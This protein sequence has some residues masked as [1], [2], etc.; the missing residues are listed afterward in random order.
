MALVAARTFLLINGADLE[1][2]QEEKYV[3]YL[4]LAEGGWAKTSWPGGC[5]RTSNG[6]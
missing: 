1:A 3:K 4:R 6:V 5:A 2:T